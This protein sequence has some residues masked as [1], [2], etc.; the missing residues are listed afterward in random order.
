VF[1]FL[2]VQRSLTYESIALQGIHTSQG[3]PMGRIIKKTVIVCTTTFSRSELEKP[4]DLAIEE[5]EAAVDNG[6]CQSG[7]VQAI[8]VDKHPVG[9]AVTLKILVED[10]HRAG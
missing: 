1:C 10:I 3:D 5:Y 7:V 4:E 8:I 9:W 2:L 6:S